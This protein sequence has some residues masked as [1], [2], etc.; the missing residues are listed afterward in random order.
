MT[1]V[2]GVIAVVDCVSIVFYVNS[3][4]LIYYGKVMSSVIISY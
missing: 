1:L 2:P 3:D 4:L